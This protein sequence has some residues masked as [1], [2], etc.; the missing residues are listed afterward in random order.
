MRE[1]LEEAYD[2]E[3]F[4]EFSWLVPHLV[5]YGFSP[6][7]FLKTVGPALKEAGGLTNADVDLFM[8]DLQTAAFQKQLNQMRGK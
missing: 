1:T 5:K 8:E 6:Q 4:D 7:A 3:E 2:G